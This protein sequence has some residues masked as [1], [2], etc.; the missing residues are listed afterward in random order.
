MWAGKQAE[1]RTSRGVGKAEDKK[2]KEQDNGWGRETVDDQEDRRHTRKREGKAEDKK[3][4]NSS[5]TK[6]PDGR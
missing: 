1:R 3:S 5:E 2:A 6:H 4:S